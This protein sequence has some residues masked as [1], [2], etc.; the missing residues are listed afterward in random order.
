MAEALAK[1]IK[2]LWEAGVALWSP[3]ISAACQ[4]GRCFPVLCW[5]SAGSCFID[6]PGING[7]ALC[8]NE[9][10]G[11]VL[12]RNGDCQQKL[13]RGGNAEC[14]FLAEHI[15]L[16]KVFQEAELSLLLLPAQ[17]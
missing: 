1:P 14:G 9:R 17:V 8:K 5:H 2:A 4:G 7:G 6:P 12:T 11:L 10:R 3:E 16:Q 15:L 13:Q